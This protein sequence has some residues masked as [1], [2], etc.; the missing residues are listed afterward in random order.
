MLTPFADATITTWR[1]AKYMV[2]KLS[3]PEFGFDSSYKQIR[4]QTH[5]KQKRTLYPAN[6]TQRANVTLR[7]RRVR[8]VLQDVSCHIQCLGIDETP[9]SLIRQ[10]DACF[11]KC[12]RQKAGSTKRTLEGL[13]AYDTIH[14]S[15]INFK[16]LY[17]GTHEN[18]TIAKTTK[19]A[20]L[21]SRG[22]ALFNDR[23]IVC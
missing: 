13:N 3:I 17:R 14:S 6:L 23:I 12:R 1:A 4:C 2:S 5:D 20:T 16:R 11:T 7:R 15:S 21:V 22:L 10:R 8:S 18:K 19:Y 9:A